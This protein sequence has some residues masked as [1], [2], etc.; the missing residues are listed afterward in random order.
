MISFA[1][2]KISIDELI[3]CSFDLNKTSYQLMLFLLK[4]HKYLTINE[5]AE[6]LGLD[7]TTVQKAIG[8]LLEKNIV[9]KKQ[10][11]LEKGGYVYIYVIDGKDEIKKKMISLL[12]TWHRDAVR[13]IK[14]W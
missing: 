11:N 10:L 9:Q 1:C 4:K 13:E 12:E 2:E 8:S 5:I 7:R 3:K 6:E 14:E